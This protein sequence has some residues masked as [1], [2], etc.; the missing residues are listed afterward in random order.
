MTIRDLREKI[1]S[2]PETTMPF[3][4]KDVFSWR[5]V[6]AEP[7]CS[8]STRETSKE[9]NLFMLDTLTSDI[10]EGWKGGEYSYHD[11][12]DIHFEVSDGSWSDGMFIQNFLL[13]N[14][15]NAAVRHIFHS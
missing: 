9:D 1:E 4:I 6:Y 10:F 13:D 5:G 12:D 14:A 2:W 15:D 3:C 7:A 11:Y 8:I